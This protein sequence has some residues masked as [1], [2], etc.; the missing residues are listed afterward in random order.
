MG[1]GGKTNLISIS[2]RAWELQTESGIN[3]AFY[4]AVSTNLIIMF[5]VVLVNIHHPH[6]Q[7]INVPRHCRSGV[8]VDGSAGWLVRV[9]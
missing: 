7:L 6:N 1:D 9:I 8:V 2:T 5:F 4:E 3:L